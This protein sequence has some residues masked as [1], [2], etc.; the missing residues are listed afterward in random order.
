MELD[1]YLL[2]IVA[3]HFGIGLGVLN[4]DL[5]DLCGQIVQMEIKLMNFGYF[6]NELHWCA[7]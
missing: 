1:G 4:D 5:V 6:F 3:V 7:D 2:K